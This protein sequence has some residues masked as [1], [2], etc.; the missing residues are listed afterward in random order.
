VIELLG[1]RRDVSTVIEERVSTLEHIMPDLA[2]AQLRTK[3]SLDRL[4]D[5]MPEFKQEMRE[6]KVEMDRRWGELANR[7]GALVEDV[8]RFATHDVTCDTMDSG[9]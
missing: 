6:F 4:S 7:L 9:G 8:V 5:E 1:W 3:R 2:Y